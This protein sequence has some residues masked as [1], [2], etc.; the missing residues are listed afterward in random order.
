MKLAEPDT[1]LTD[2]QEDARAISSRDSSQ[3]RAKSKTLAQGST[4]GHMRTPR[5][6]MCPCDVPTDISFAAPA[7]S[8]RGDMDGGVACKGAFTE[9]LLSISQ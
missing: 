1:G 7:C 4:S 6:F 2:T 9:C 5:V 3:V 8:L